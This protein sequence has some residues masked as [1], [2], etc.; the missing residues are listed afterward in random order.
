VRTS[1]ARAIA[2][3]VL[4]PF[5]V[6]RILPRIEAVMTDLPLFH[7]LDAEPHHHA[8]TPAPSAAHAHLR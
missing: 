7:G 1:R 3:V 4:G 5:R 8:P 2:D 6:Q